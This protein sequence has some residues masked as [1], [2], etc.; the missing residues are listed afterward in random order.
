[1]PIYKTKNED[2]FKKWSP[3]MAYVLGFF[4]ADGNMIKNKRGA[5][6][7]SFYSTDKDLLEK[8][9]L[10]LKSNLKISARKMDARF[11][12]HKQSYVL[13]IGSKEIF[14]DLIHLGM[15]PNKS[16]TIKMP[17]VP[18]KYLPHFLRGYF[19]GDGHVSVSTY[20][21]KDRKNKSTII[22]TGFTSG[23]KKFLEGLWKM[24]KKY[25]VIEGGTLYHTDGYHLCFSTHDSLRL[26]NFMYQKEKSLYLERKKVIFERYLNVLGV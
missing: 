22:I 23:S 10:N 24:L 4:A 18:K 19:D 13:Q 3:E 9:K 5:H 12:N 7:V 11:S 8:V 21:K 2:F 25:R 17:I 6:F 14:N 15:T 16:L 20:Q 1:M 26:Y